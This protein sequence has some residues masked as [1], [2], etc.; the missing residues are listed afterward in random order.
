MHNACPGQDQVEYLPTLKRSG[1]FCD[2]ILKDGAWDGASEDGASECS[3]TQL[4]K[5]DVRVRVRVRYFIYS[6]I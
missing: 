3:L 6:R 2:N 1:R 5:L 4:G